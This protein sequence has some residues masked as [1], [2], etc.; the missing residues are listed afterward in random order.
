[1]R[2]VTS[3]PVARWQVPFRVAVHN[4]LGGCQVANIPYLLVFVLGALW[5]VVH[6]DT[7]TLTV[8]GAR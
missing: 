8:R 7:K 3:D 6:T 1:M 4:A 2:E 5:A